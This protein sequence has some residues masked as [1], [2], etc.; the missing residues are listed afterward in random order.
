[1][2]HGVA[3]PPDGDEVGN[4]I[5]GVYTDTGFNNEY[6]CYTYSYGLNEVTVTPYGNTWAEQRCK[7]LVWEQNCGGLS[8]EYSGGEVNVPIL[9]GGGGGGI[10]WTNYTGSPSKDNGIASNSVSYGI[11]YA[12][13]V[14]GFKKDL[15][16]KPRSRAQKAINQKKAYNTQKALK[17]KG[18]TKSVKEIK[19]GKIANLKAGGV[20]LGVLSIGLT[21]E[22]SFTGLTS[23]GASFTDLVSP[24]AYCKTFPELLTDVVICLFP[25]NIQKQ[26]LHVYNAYIGIFLLKV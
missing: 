15:W 23:F 11:S 21:L 5:T 13:L 8:A 10:F 18:I 17:A 26:V 12:G 14:T 6:D 25:F 4:Y 19:A 24:T 20:A 3:P 16:E 1:N 7:E 22:G 2:G 9:S